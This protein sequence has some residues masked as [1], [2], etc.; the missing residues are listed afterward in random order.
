MNLFNLGTGTASSG[1][2]NDFGTSAHEQLQRDLQS[3]VEVRKPASP[4]CLV[5]TCPHTML[6][7]RDGHSF[8]RV[9]QY[10]NFLGMSF[11]DETNGGY[12]VWTRK[13]RERIKKERRP[14]PLNRDPN[15]L[16]T[17]ELASNPWFRGLTEIFEHHKQQHHQAQSGST[18]NKIKK[19]SSVSSSMSNNSSSSMSPPPLTMHVDVHG[20]MNPGVAPHFYKAE[21][22]VGLRAMEICDQDFIPPAASGTES[23]GEHQPTSTFDDSVDSE[24]ASL[25]PP[26]DRARR[27]KRCSQQPSSSS[28]DVPEESV[29]TSS[30]QHYDLD[31]GKSLYTSSRNVDEDLETPVKRKPPDM[32]QG[33][34]ASFESSRTAPRG[35]TTSSAGG[36]SPRLNARGISRARLVRSILVRRLVTIL[37]KYDYVG[38]N[39]AWAHGAVSDYK[40]VEGQPLKRLTGACPDPGRLTLSQQT[41]LIGYDVS[42]QIELS[43]ALRKVLGSDPFFRSDFG[44]MFRDVYNELVGAYIMIFLCM[45]MI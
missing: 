37:K 19:S 23:D 30:Q 21:I 22:F 12:V 5:F 43:Q 28:S 18:Q 40:P 7:A 36:A 24:D 26:Q 6:L 34:C 35:D 13:E 9:E 32:W 11:A 15:Y 8:H 27:T 2:G 44:T 1:N 4:M 42:I 20:C 3:R 39:N 29:S 16:R 14:D 10:T 41:V 25:S 45:T 31:P 38:A 33:A 17:E